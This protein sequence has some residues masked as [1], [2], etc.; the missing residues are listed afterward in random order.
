MATKKAKRYEEGG[1]TEGQNKRIG[2]DVRARALAAI[3]AGGQKDE[4]PAAPKKTAKLAKPDYSNEDIER[5]GL[6]EKG[7][8][9][10]GNDEENKLE[11][12]RLFNKK[13]VDTTSKA[14]PE[15]V[16]K[17]YIQA[18]EIQKA[19]NDEAKKPLPKSV[20]FRKSGG[21]VSSGSKVAGRLATRG[22]GIARGGK[23]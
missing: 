9:P 16:R 18:A 20:V 6:G 23:K 21:T 8:I 13:P 17:A 1:V 15:K 7:D 3:A 4:A 14:D 11:S 19:K 22:Y 2:D 10:V 5:M 12:Q